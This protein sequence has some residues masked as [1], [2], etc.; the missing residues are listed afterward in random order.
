MNTGISQKSAADLKLFNSVMGHV[1][2]GNF[3]QLFMYNPNKEADRNAVSQ[4]VNAQIDKAIEFEGTVSVS[5][6]LSR[7]LLRFRNILTITKGE[8]GIG[9]GKKVTLP[10]IQSFL[11]LPL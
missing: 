7:P 3:H 9:L 8:H 1:G 4:L 11:G 5:A 6:W 2:D 10:I